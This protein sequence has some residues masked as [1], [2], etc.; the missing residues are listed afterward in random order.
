MKFSR[1]I[2]RFEKLIG[3][4]DQG[5]SI[6]PEK[7]QKLQQLLSDKISRYQAKLADNQDPDRQSRLETRLKV[8][9]AQ[10]EKSRNL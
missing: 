10:L 5:Q 3:L 9:E 1:L 4:S 7:L 8:V 2:T 6:K